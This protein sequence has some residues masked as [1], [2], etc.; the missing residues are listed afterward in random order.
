[1]APF[2]RILPFLL[3]ACSK[4]SFQVC[5]SPGCAADGACETLDKLQALAPPQV[6]VSAGTCE[7]LCGSGPVVSF[8]G[9][10]F[11][12]VIHKRVAGKALLDLLLSHYPIHPSLLEGYELVAQAKQ[13]F[14]KKDYQRAIPLY[15]RGIQMALVPTKEQFQDDET[16][17]G[18]R[19]LVR[20]YAQEAEAHLA[21]ADFQG[22]LASAQAACNLSNHMDSHSLEV[23][24]NICQVRKDA[25]GELGA[26]QRLFALPQDPN[27]PREVANQRR[28]LGFRL[29]KLERELAA[30]KL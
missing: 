8:H 7:S 16:Q 14:L 23:L 26:L 21:I 9:E 3:A 13:Y 17:D 5:L 30:T 20:A 24:A 11:K 18:M 12:K 2:A 29:Q 19:W 6:E 10:D 15:E 27:M 25:R 28:T 4:T 22:A 1:M